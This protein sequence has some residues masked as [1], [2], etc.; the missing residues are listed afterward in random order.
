VRLE[1]Q[2]GG[3][4]L[5]YGVVKVRITTG[6]RESGHH[7]DGEKIKPKNEYHVTT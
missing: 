7:S 6:S 5:E 4:S 1:E 2:C 3:N